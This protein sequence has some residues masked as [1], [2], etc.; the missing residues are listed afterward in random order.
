MLELTLL[1]QVLRCAGASHVVLAGDPDQLVSVEVG[2]VLRDVVEAGE[3]SPAPLEVLVT[4]LTTSHRSNDAIV[5]LAA[6]INAGDADALHRA[7]D[8]HPDELRLVSSPASLVSSVITQASELRRLASS[9]DEQGALKALGAQVVLCANRNGSQSLTWWNTKVADALE[10]SQPSTPGQ[11][12]R[13][14][15]GTPIMVLKN[16][17]SATRALADRLSNGD[18]GVICD[19]QDGPEVVFLPVSDSPRRRA[20]RMIDQATAAWAFTI[21]KS[22][23]SEYEQVVV[24]LPDRPNRI[25]SRELLYTAV[26]RAKHGVV[27]IGSTEV[28]RA[29]LSRRVER[30]SGLTERLRCR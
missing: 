21:H 7:I 27:I 11:G 20:L 18:V 1:D 30:V 2:A 4:R 29:S 12:E 13:F 8:A 24:S 10:R 22:Q 14:A 19:T 26:T 5:E 15:S 17:S 3:G 25:L 23:G 6:A 28:L 9:G 16:E